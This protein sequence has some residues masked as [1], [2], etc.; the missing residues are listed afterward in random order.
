MSGMKRSGASI[1]A[2]YTSSTGAPRPR[3]PR[4][5]T[6][7]H[8]A[9]ASATSGGPDSITDA[10]GVD[11]ST[12]AAVTCSTRMSAT[13]RA[14]AATPEALGLSSVVDKGVSDFGELNLQFAR[15]VTNALQ[16]M[17]RGDWSAILRQYLAF[18]DEVAASGG[19]ARSGSAG[20][21]FSGPSGFV[22]LGSG[23]SGS[24]T[25]G[26]S[27]PHSRYASTSSGAA[28]VAQSGAASG[29][30]ST[31]SRTTAGMPV[32]SVA[33]EISIYRASINGKLL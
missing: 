22:G 17:P 11:W 21:S 16:D 26:V 10:D 13:A 4:P 32:G 6:A 31:S 9:A 15:A 2:L 1:D 18:A 3:A 30:P 23:S 25:H 5:R 33:P 29:A 12:R 20:G 7:A 8:D 27:A 28:A 19:A 14:A 24:S